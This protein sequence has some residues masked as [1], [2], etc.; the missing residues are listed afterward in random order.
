MK[1]LASL[2]W[3]KIS[4]FLLHLFSFQSFLFS[5]DFFLEFRKQRIQRF[6]RA[7]FLDIYNPDPVGGRLFVQPLSFHEDV[8]VEDWFFGESVITSSSYS[9]FF[10]SDARS[11][12]PASSQVINSIYV[13]KGI[14]INGFR[15]EFGGIYR[16]HQDIRE[17]NLS[18]FLDSLHRAINQ[19]SNIA[20]EAHRFQTSA[21]RDGVSLIGP[22]GEWFM[23][24]LQVYT[25]YQLL[26]DEPGK[27]TP[28]LSL[29]LTL[30]LPVTTNSFDTLGVALSMG[31]SKRIG[32]GHKF[33]FAGDICYQGIDRS[34]FQT[35]DPDLMVR[36]WYA[37]IFAG[38][39]LELGKPGGWYM[40]LGHRYS[41][42][43]VYYRRH[44]DTQI[45]N[46][47]QA[48]HIEYLKIAY[49]SR[50]KKWEF[51]LMA[52]EDLFLPFRALEPDFLINGGVVF[53]DF[54]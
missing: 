29:K 43:K 19:S 13:S 17:S 54:F 27:H 18:R 49:S 16:I 20:P 2:P 6:P 44:P 24:T 9:R 10:F 21:G 28:N 12:A 34:S 35:R 47:Q 5:S 50:G 40:T 30:R 23:E 51:Y 33:L 36:Q 14:N 15:F 4:A 52:Q 37:E 45:D 1:P 41:S 25:K 53:H 38:F 42:R 7:D 48:S 22:N 39:S 3:I 31:M 11:N 26:Y 32:Q 46:R 8:V